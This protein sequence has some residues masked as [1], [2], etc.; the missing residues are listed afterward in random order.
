MIESSVRIEQD[1]TRRRVAIAALLRGNEVSRRLTGGDHAIVTIAA[2]AEYFV[3]VDEAGDVEAQGRMTGLTHVAG[4][5][6]G[7]RL[8][9]NRR[10]RRMTLSTI[11]RQAAMKMVRR[12]SRIDR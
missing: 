4:R 7:A 9:L 11:A 6:V 1:E 5:N 2:F 3:V 12:S 8:G 10:T